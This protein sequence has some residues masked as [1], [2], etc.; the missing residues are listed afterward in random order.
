MSH[1]KKL[2]VSEVMDMLISL[3]NHATF[4]HIQKTTYTLYYTTI[5]SYDLSI[6]NF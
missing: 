4:I 1:N 3:L 6:K 2:Q 5:H